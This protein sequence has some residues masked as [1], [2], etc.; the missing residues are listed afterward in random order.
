M[1]YF[2]IS[3]IL[4]VLLIGSTT[5]HAQEDS[6]QTQELSLSDGTIDNQFEYV[7]QKSNRYKDSNG[8]IYK[9]VRRE[10][11]F[12]LKSNTLDS[13]KA[14]QNQLDQTNQTITTQRNEIDGLQTNLRSTQDTLANTN[15]EKDSMALFGF[16]MSKGAYNMLL[17]SVIAALLGLLIF[18]IYKFKNSNAITK[19]SKKSLM[20]IETEFEEHRRVALEREQK[21]RRQLQDEINKQ[22]GNS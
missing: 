10:W 9:V 7:I 6:T 17:W 15:K 12:T 13:I 4:L 2:K 22:K 20:E 14:I 8:R 16:Q 3:T 5:M 1:K 11:L 21:V 18:F 19:A